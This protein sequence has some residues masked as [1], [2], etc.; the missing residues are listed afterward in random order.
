MRP[1]FKN[2]HCY[3]CF[4][5]ILWPEQVTCLARSHEA[6]EETPPLNGKDDDSFVLQRHS[7]GNIYG[8]CFQTT[9]QGVWGQ[10]PQKGLGLEC[11]GESQLSRAGLAFPWRYPM[12]STPVLLQQPCCFPKTR[13]NHFALLRFSLTVENTFL[14]IYGCKLMR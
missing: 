8:H 10:A 6:Q 2:A 1:G 5:R 13:E 14:P 3:F 12:P 11:Y 9:H 7:G 4:H